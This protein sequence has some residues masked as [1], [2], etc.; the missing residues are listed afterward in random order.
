MIPQPKRYISDFEQ[1]GFGMFVH[2]G[3]YSQIA[4][5]EWK[6]LFS[7]M[8]MEEYEKLADT[9]TAENFDADKIVLLAK[10]TV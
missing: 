6:Y 5:G 2:W 9:F 3:L 1:M 8:K 4:K 7:G 10:N